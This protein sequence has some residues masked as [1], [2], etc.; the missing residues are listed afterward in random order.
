MPYFIYGQTETEHI[1]QKDKKMSALIQQYGM[2]KRKVTPD[3]FEALVTSIIAQQI[4]SK[5]AATVTQRFIALI[6]KITP[7]LIRQTNALRIQECGMTHKK[8][9]YLKAAAEVVLNGTIDLSAFP[10]ME[11]EAI[12]QQLVKLPGVGRWTAEMLLLHSLRRPDV[13]SYDDLAIRRSLMSMH[14]LS[15]LTKADFEKYRKRYSPHCS[16]AMIYLWKYSS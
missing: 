16:V 12:I 11:D 10:A 7:E 6:G 14:N 8:A 2:L 5:A 15:A 3:L 4:S 1:S 13:F 9:G